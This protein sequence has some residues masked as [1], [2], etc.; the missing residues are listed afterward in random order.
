VEEAPAA[1]VRP[2]PAAR[3][4]VAAPVAST[5]TTA[6]ATLSLEIEGPRAVLKSVLAALLDKDIEIPP[7]KLRVRRPQ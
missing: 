4:A 1:A 6:R 5:D 2:Q 3:A 7:L